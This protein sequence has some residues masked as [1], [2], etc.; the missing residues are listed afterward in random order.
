M[1]QLKT[2][3]WIAAGLV[4]LATI[5]SFTAKPLLAQIRAALIASIDEPGRAPY[6]SLATFFASSPVCAVAGGGTGCNLD[7]P[8][9]PA[10]KRLVLT[11]ITG[12][13]FVTSP[14]LVR[15]LQLGSTT[16]AFR[17]LIPSALIGPILAPLGG[18][19]NMVGVSA[20]VKHFFDAG[21]HPRLLVTTEPTQLS[22]LDISEI[23]LSGYLV[24]CSTGGP[25]STVV[26]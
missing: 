14:G 17:G 9:V 16:V 11:N 12:V 7:F 3:I 10:G 18:T 23:T 13:I 4:M 26:R 25:C 2:C 22:N 5:G 15:D 21:D 24:D 19:D 8:S 20:S 6:E 1:R